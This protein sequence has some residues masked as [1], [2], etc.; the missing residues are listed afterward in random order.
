MKTK[1]LLMGILNV[2][3]DSFY[4]KSRTTTVE[5]AVDKALQLQGEGA[6]VLDIGG[7]STRPGS[8]PVSEKEEI[9]RIL[10][11]LEALQ[12]KITI[13]LSID[14][15]KPAV[16]KAAIKAGATLLNDITGFSNEE[17]IAVALETGCELC[18]MHMQG[19]PQT[20]QVNPHYEEGVTAHLIA[21]FEEKIKILVRKGIQTEKIIL[22]PGI[23]FGKTV[24]HNLEIIHNLPLLRRLGFRVLLGMSRKSFLSKILNQPTEHLLPATI[25]VSTLAISNGNAA[26]R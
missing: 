26:Y 23:G 12:E 1:T 9:A 25:A 17:M 11:V 15:T 8:P 6:D 22:D 3:P 7:E 18:V 4:E 5:N 14:T 19:T 13:P 16:A 21:W 20:M 2:T 24:A 10:P